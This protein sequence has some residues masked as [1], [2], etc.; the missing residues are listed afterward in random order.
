MLTNQFP[1]YQYAKV[2]TMQFCGLRSVHLE[3]STTGYLPV[4]NARTI[5]KTTEDV[6]FLSFV[7]CTD[8]RP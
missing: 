3:E 4:D 1:T 5:L 2:W 7:K 8:W 6:P